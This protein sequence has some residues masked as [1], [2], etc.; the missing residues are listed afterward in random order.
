MFACVAYNFPSISGKATGLSSGEQW[1]A[2]RFLID[3]ET[4]VSAAPSI[5]SGDRAGTICPIL[6]GIAAG[7]DH[8]L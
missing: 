1:T 8:L 5:T 4:I 7:I 2:T 6:L 3:D